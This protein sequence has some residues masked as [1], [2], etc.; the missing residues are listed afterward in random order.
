V[1]S[2]A[3]SSKS[4]GTRYDPEPWKRLC[5]LSIP[6]AIQRLNT[7]VSGVPSNPPMS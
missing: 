4:H 1:T 5:E 6:N 3:S 7:S 2:T